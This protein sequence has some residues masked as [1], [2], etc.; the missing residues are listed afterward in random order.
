[1]SPRT[2]RARALD[3]LKAIDEVEQF[4]DYP[5]FDAFCADLK[6]VRASMACF[7]AIGEATNHIPKSIKEK[8]PEVPWDQI[9]GMR[10]R[11]T[12]EYFSVDETVIW[13]T[14]KQRLPSFRIVIQKILD[15]H[16]DEG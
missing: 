6:A 1:M 8:Y 9:R 15:I 13:R 14:A 2:W 4:T 11:V 3:I 7:I 12:H 10:N 5:S 16:V